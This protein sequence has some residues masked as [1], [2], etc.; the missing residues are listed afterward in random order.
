MFGELEEDQM[1]YK[2]SVTY[3]TTVDFG[4]LSKGVIKSLLEGEDFS[5]FVA[6]EEPEMTGFTADPVK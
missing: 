3:V 5:I 2:V 1:E 6:A 4:E